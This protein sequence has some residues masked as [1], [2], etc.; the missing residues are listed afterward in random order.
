MNYAYLLLCA[1]DSIYAGWTNDLQKR[2]HAHNEGHGAKYTRGRRPV[3]LAY[4]EA[5]ATKEEAQSRECQFKKLR[6]TERL[7]LIRAGQDDA[8]TRALIEAVNT[9]KL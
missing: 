8:Q 7:S 1:D 5:F 3:R 6:R 4:A 9:G 2:L